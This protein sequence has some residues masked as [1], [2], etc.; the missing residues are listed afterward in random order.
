MEG[1]SET[2]AA[3]ADSLKVSDT[4]GHPDGQSTRKEEE[5]CF[6]DCEETFHAERTSL[7]INQTEMT[8]SEG[9]VN[10]LQTES[11]RNPD[12]G[13]ESVQASTPFEGNAATRGHEPLEKDAVLGEGEYER[14]GEEDERKTDTDSELKEEA[15]KP[16]E[17]DDEYL[18]EAEKN[19]TEEEKEVSITS[20]TLNAFI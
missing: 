10:E 9:T 16:S 7:A 15:T 1:D 5:D 17:Y 6:Y 20:F 12:T 8:H 19:L 14:I 4:G 11:N 2:L 13:E 18:R 3:M